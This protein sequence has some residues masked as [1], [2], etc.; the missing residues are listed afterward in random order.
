[1]NEFIYTQYFHELLDYLD[2]KNNSIRTMIEDLYTYTSFEDHNIISRLD[3]FFTETGVKIAEINHDTPGG[4]IETY[5]LN[6][7]E[8]IEG[9]YI[10]PNKDFAELF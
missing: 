4:W 10:N 6:A 5:F 9:P 1:M 3:L 8:H 7:M 2:I